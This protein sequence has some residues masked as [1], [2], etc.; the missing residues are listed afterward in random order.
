MVPSQVMEWDRVR[1]HLRMTCNL[2]CVTVYLYSFPL[3]S[4]LRLTAGKGNLEKQ[5]ADEGG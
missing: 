5:T 4:G 2:Q 3:Y 1:F